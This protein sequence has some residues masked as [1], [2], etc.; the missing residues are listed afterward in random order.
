MSTLDADSI[1]VTPVQAREMIERDGA[2]LIDVRETYEWDAGHISG[3]RNIALERLPSAAETIDKERPVI[4]QCRV[5]A[6]SAMA[7]QAFRAAGYQAWSMAGGLVRW[8]DDGLP[9]DPDDGGVA[10]H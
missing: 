2:P 6:R 8:V 9:I 4:F 7:T 10:D 3:A 5:G 1:E